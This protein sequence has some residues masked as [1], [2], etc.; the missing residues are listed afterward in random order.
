[1]PQKFKAGTQSDTRAPMLT[2]VLFA[3]AKSE[4]NPSTHEWK[5]KR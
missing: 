3:K 5:N 4:S 2:A 1:V